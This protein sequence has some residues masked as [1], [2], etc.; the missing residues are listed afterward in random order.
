VL[1]GVVFAD[2]L[3]R[4]M[5]RRAVAA[6]TVGT[7]I[8]WYDF[9]LYSTA[10]AVVFPKLFFPKQDPYTGVM[11][12]FSTFFV[13]FAA[14]PVGAALF[15]HYGDRLGRKVTLVATILVMGIGTLLIGVIPTYAAIGIWGSVVL[16]L[17]RAM[18][19]IGIGGEWGGSVLLALEWNE[20]GRRGLIGALPQFGVPVGLVLS[21][22]AFNFFNAVSGSEFTTWGW[23]MP[24]LLSVVLI[25]VGLAIRLGVLDTPV[26]TALLEERRT[27]R[28]PVLAAMR[29]GLP[30][31]VLSALARVGQF[32]QFYIFTSFILVYG[33]T[34]LHFKRDFVLNGTLIMAAISLV[35]V[36]LF[37]YLSDVYGR[38][39]IYLAGCLVMV[40]FP[41]L[42]Y[43]LLDTRLVPLVLLAIAISL[44]LHDMQWGP[45]A[46]LIAESFSGRIRYSGASLGFQLPSIIAGGP[47]PIVATFL[48]QRFHNSVAVAMYLAFCAAISA[49]ATLG[50]KD[51]RGRNMA[52]EYDLP[53]SS[54][55]PAL[56]GNPPRAA[57]GPAGP[58]SWPS[59]D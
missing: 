58:R 14:R 57:L 22:G 44:P 32:T 53:G 23:R 52:V 43:Q 15:G 34:V 51:N 18:Q 25:A 24:F 17:L 5:K 21:T 54:S 55:L 47:A 50:L 28:R 36:P 16:S 9:F 2:R 30:E 41:L 19:G 31:I 48:I 6:A 46:S 7:A 29:R 45:M 1:S 10:A 38:R 40:P 26:F 42:Y 39:R 27:E 35:T 20:R 49:L 59:A 3:E 37:G 56:A 13:G 33:T 4:R 8:E 12:S 11:L